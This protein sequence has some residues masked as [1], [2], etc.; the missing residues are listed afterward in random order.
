MKKLLL[1]SFVLMTL[2]SLA[3]LLQPHGHS[4]CLNGLKEQCKA[5][6]KL[7]YA[8]QGCACLSSGEFF[9]P[10]F[11]M[12]AMIKC[13]GGTEFS[14]LQQLDE[15]GSKVYA[16]CGCFTVNKGMIPQGS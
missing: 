14:G 3:T 11:C 13:V 7:Y 2:P 16:G 1:L 5:G 12:S 8:N 15:Q 4:M 9:E 6:T 10:D